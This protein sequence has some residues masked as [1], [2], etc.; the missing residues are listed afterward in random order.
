MRYCLVKRVTLKKLKKVSYLRITMN[1]KE[2]LKQIWTDLYAPNANVLAVI[3]TYFHPEYEQCINGVILR[4][5]EYI[6]HVIAQKNNMIV[7]SIDYIHILANNNELFS[8]YIPR[9]KD[10]A[11][12]PISAEVIAYFKFKDQQII[13]I[14]GQ[15]R[16]IEG[17][18]AV[19]DM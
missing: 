3:E 13:H 18:P 7:E 8:L 10:I 4:R 6:D 17:K 14:H 11:G 16:M 2:L 12:N 5:T 9:G 15:V 1:Y 19:V